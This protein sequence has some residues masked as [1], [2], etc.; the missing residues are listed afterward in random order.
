MIQT[1]WP[2]IIRPISH[3]PIPYG[4]YD[5]SYLGPGFENPLSKRI[6]LFKQS[7]GASDWFQEEGGYN[8]EYGDLVKQFFYNL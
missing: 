5:M 3:G 1:I 6:E 4:P 2:H 8:I 7:L